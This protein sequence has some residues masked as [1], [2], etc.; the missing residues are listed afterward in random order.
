[1]W[2]IRTET[3]LETGE[4]HRMFCY[5]E[6]SEDG[7]KVMYE[8][9]ISEN[10]ALQLVKG[11]IASY[12]QAVEVLINEV[13]MEARATQPPARPVVPKPV[14]RDRLPEPP[15]DLEEPEFTLADLAP[16]GGVERDAPQG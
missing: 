12:P 10:A 14:E 7:S 5:Q 11:M 1:M 8:A 4:S 9:V 3:D 13:N 15:M 6:V 2:K 16:R